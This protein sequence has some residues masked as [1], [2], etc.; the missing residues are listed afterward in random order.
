MERSYPHMWCHGSI[1]VAAERM[2]SAEHDLLARAD[3][4]GGL[5]GA[6]A[7][8]ERLLARP[9]GPG[10]GDEANASVCHG[11]SGLIDLF[12]EA[13]EATRE[14][15]WLALA[16]DLADLMLNDSR[17]AGGWRSGIPGGWPTPGLMLGHAGIGWTLLRVADPE[18]TGS[19]WRF[20]VRPSVTQ[21]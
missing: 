13:W 6:R 16:G 17:R 7:H 4:V 3:A 19:A 5:A 1:G 10:A 8:A 2:G 9:L 21:P 18:R 15:D 20:D 11:V 12:M 14:T